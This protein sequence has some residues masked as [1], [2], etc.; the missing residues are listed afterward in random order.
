V[1]L[2]AFDLLTNRWAVQATAFEAGEITN[3]NRM[4]VQ[5]LL[6]STLLEGWAVITLESLNFVCLVS[7]LQ[8]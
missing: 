2:F 7:R 3:E 6:E 1:S 4:G 5:G 8:I